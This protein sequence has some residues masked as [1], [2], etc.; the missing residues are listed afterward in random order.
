[1]KVIFFA[2]AREAA[3]SAGFLLPVKAAL[4]QP[5]FW[6]LLIAAS[7]GLAVFQKT[8]RL[9]RKETYLQADEMLHPG[10]EIAVL[11]PVSGG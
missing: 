9:A 6:A 2:Q 11:P 3:G 10:D 7:P 8:A 4:T 1:M 5:E